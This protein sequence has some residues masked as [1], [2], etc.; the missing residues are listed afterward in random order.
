[1]SYVRFKGMSFFKQIRTEEAARALIWKTKFEGKEFVCPDCKSEKYWGFTCEPEIRKCQGCGK[2][3]RLPAGTMFEN[4]KISMLNWTR[5]IY[6]VMSSKRGISALELQRRLELGSYHTALG[7]LKKIRH[8]LLQRDSKYQ[9]S[10]SIELDGTSFGRA[11]NLNQQEVMVAIETKS[12]IDEK[13]N[14]KTKAGFAKVIVAN[15]TRE[16]AEKFI[17]KNIKPGSSINT[18]AGKAFTHTSVP[19]IDL[20]YRE[21]DSKQ[22]KVNEW[23]PWV[24]RFISNAKSWIVGTHHGVRAKYLELYLAEYTYRFN[25]RHDPDS[26]F[27]RAISAMSQADPMTLGRLT[28]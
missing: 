24:H 26:L 12:W 23:L 28:A 13:G 21:M 5:A 6:F 27:H 15:E 10:D 7:L 20:D 2:H 8:S 22:E 3:V 1:M 18:A 25:R 9:L 19:G 14:E 17:S 11:K 16:N 4:S